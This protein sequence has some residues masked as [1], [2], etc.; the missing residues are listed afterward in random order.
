MKS[1][2]IALALV[3]TAT[4]QAEDFDKDGFAVLEMKANGNWILG[5]THLLESD[6]SSADSDSDAFALPE[7]NGGANVFVSG[8]RIA[9][10][11]EK[12]NGDKNLDAQIRKVSIIFGNGE[13]RE[14]KL[15]KKEGHL[16]VT[17]KKGDGFQID[18]ATERCVRSVVVVGE[19]YEAGKNH[20]ASVVEVIGL[21]D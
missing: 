7:C 8:L 20:S 4:A 5:R 10:P 15:T 6:K 12:P 17:N 1:V 13:T 2:L 21:I 14:I 3:L 16:V 18:F 19:Q 9:A 11:K